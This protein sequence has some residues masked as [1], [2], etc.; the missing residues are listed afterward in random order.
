MKLATHGPRKMNIVLFLCMGNYYRSRFA[1]EIF[2]DLA[3]R[4]GLPWKAQSRGLAIERGRD[5]VG[6][7]SKFALSALQERGGAGELWVD[8]LSLDLIQPVPMP[9]CP[10]V[11]AHEQKSWVSS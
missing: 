4:G 11:F 1:E 6:A 5:N 2:N 8:R 10:I 9:A 7:T 3:E